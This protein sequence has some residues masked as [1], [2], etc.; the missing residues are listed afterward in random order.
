MIWQLAA[1][2][3]IGLLF[4]VRRITGWIRGR[5]RAIAERNDPVA[6]TIPPHA[7]SPPDDIP[8]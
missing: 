5:F 3:M 1:A 7:G 4:Y 2:G 8:R 6:K